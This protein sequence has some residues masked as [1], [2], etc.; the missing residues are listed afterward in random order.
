MTLIGHSVGG[1]LAVTFTRQYPNMV[2]KLILIDSTGIPS[3]QNI[4]LF[5]FSVIRNALLFGHKKVLENV[6]SIGWMIVQMK[7]SFNLGLYAHQADIRQQAQQLRSK[8]LLLWGENDVLEPLIQGEEL[9]KAIPNSKLVVLK[10]MDHDWVL[11]SPELF[12]KNIT[13]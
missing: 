13:N 4:F 9:Q 5:A 11:H 2:E 6:A 8:T 12:W 3:T 1:A 10:N 7:M